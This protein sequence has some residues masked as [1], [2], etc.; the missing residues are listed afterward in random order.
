MA[1]VVVT[2]G[3]GFV[4]SHLVDAFLARGDRVTAIDNLLTGRL[5]DVMFTGAVYRCI[6]V[7]PDGTEVKAD[8][9]R[10]EGLSRGDEVGVDWPPRD[11]VVLGA[12]S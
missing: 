4:G 11:A 12:E 7:L 8:L 2:G 6:V 3:A 10:L 5:D 1:H 9:A